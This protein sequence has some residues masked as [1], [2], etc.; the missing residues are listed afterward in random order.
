M[1]Y[2]VQFQTLPNEP[3]KDVKVCRAHAIPRIG[4]TLDLDDEEFTVIAVFHIAEP[5]EFGSAEVE[6]IYDASGD[7]IVV[8]VR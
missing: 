7:S 5:L 6:P 8:R 4:E 1:N 2:T 3:R